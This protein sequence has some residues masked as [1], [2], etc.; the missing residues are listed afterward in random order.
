[1]RLADHEG[2]RV[3]CRVHRLTLPFEKLGRD[4]AVVDDLP[5]DGLDVEDDGI[6]A[7]VRDLLHEGDDLLLGVVAVEVR[8]GVDPEG[9]ALHP[10]RLSALL[11]E[12]VTRRE[13]VDHHPRNGRQGRGE[14]E[15]GRG[16]HRVL[17]SHDEG[18]EKRGERHG[19]K[20]PGG[21]GS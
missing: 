5:G 9:A 17:A 12:A 8:G 21:K 19:R 2:E 6:E 16:R 11:R 18:G 1:M 13:A 3:E 14:L 20:V 10:A 15:T 7:D 4:A